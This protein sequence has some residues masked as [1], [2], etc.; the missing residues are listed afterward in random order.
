[1]KL[2]G[3]PK[4]QAMKNILDD[5]WPRKLREQ[6]GLDTLLVSALNDEY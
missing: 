2:E 4:A 5:I 3:I 6:P 1:M